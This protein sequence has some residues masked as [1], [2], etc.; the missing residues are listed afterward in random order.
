M[1]SLSLAMKALL[2]SM[3]LAPLTVLAED[4]QEKAQAMARKSINA[5]G[6]Q[7]D[8]CTERYMGEVPDA[9]GT[10]M[11]KVTVIK[12]GKV[13]RAVVETALP[14]SRSLKECLERIA[15][16]WVLPPPQ[17]DEPEDLSLTVPVQKGAKFRIP[18]P[19]EET[20]PGD[21]PQPDGFLQFTPKFL[22][23]YGEEGQ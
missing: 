22:R 9:R 14:Q 5:T 2:V 21:A 12:D 3:M 8:Q 11:V 15:K 13:G 16:K 7:I 18:E 10:A 17:T 4:D 1:N 20:K 19:G 23:N 6:P